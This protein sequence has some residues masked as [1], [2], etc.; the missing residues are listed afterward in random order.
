MN[1][2]NKG[3]KNRKEEKNR[4]NQEMMQG[5]FETKE[6]GKTGKMKEQGES[7]KDEGYE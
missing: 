4:G 6:G 3:G 7:R 5:M 2:T 1:E